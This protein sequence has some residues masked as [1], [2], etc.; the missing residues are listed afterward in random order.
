MKTIVGVDLAGMY[1][2][3]L[4]LCIE[5]QIPNQQ[6][7]FVHAVEPIPELAPPMDPVI[8]DTHAWLEHLRNAGEL[9]AQKAE[10][11]ACSKG[12]LSRSIVLDGSPIAV[13][14][15]EARRESADL[16]AIGAARRSGIN[17]ILFGSVARGLAIGAKQSLLVTKT[18]RRPGLPIR[19]LLATDHSQYAKRCFDRLL[20]FAP[21]GME[22]ID[23]LTAYDLND[24]VT[25]LLQK[26]SP[27]IQGDLGEWVDKDIR[28][29]TEDVAVTLGK[30]GYV[31]RAH[32]M[33]GHP[34]E[35]LPRVMEETG[36]NLLFMGAQGHGFLERLLI[37]SISMHQMFAESY[38]VFLVRA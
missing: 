35:V 17:R 21:Q 4:E 10:S 31:S 9:A 34:N 16:I 29:Q 3:A 32:V 12:I 2:P 7:K 28:L 26:G 23:V 38:P 15:E 8:Y 18:E 20:Q 27:H 30:A 6:F 36:A 14:E 37:G 11:Y 25:R 5:L 19:A 1:M 33:R 24:E 22:W 13:L